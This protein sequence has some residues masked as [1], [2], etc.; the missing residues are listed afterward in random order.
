MINLEDV[1]EAIE[2]END[3]LKH[4]Y[5]KESGIIIYV[6]NESE[7]KYIN[8][9]D[10]EGLED[11]EK[12]LFLVLKDF[13][14]NREKYVSLPTGKEID[15]EKMMREFLEV[16][17]ANKEEF[18]DLDLRRLKEK[19][20]DMG[21]LISWYDYREEREKRIAEEWCIKN[22]IEYK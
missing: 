6:E 3:E 20:E 22:N 19:I 2:F 17:K 13:K 15:E 8:R 16:N 12:E 18:N 21:M 11:W 5:N 14:E 1:I 4:Y 9:V 10:E 7:N